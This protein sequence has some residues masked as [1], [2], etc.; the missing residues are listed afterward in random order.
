MAKNEIR[1]HDASL[2]P[3][4]QALVSQVGLV[5]GECK[6][7]IHEGSIQ[8]VEFKPEYRVEFCETENGISEPRV[9]FIRLHETKPFVRSRLERAIFEQTGRFGHVKVKVRDGVV[10]DWHFARRHKYN[11]KNTRTCS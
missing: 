3:D 2:R 6:L 8:F 1:A 10:F 4:L 7:V 9:E 11:R 5:M